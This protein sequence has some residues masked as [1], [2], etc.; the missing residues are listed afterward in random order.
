MRFPAVYHHGVGGGHLTLN[1]WVAVCCTNPARLFG[2]ARKGHIAVGFDADLVVF[3]PDKKV[4][5]S[6][7][8]LHE[9]AGWTLYE[10]ITLKGWP[11]TT[12]SRGRVIVEGGEFVGEAG[13][14]R[15]IERRFETGD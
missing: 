7:D 3:D 10:G 5:I 14:G 8:T 11:T 9:A 13:Y 4:T 2:F 1:Q 12:I 6:P 15:F